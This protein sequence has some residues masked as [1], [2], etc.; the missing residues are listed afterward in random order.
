MARMVK[1]II[2]VAIAVVVV[3]SLS[4]GIFKSMSSHRYV[5]GGCIVRLRVLDGAKDEWALGHHKSTNDVPT[6]DDIRPYLPKRWSSE[7]WGYMTNG[8]P[9]CPDGGYYILGRVGG[10]CQVF[11]WRPGSFVSAVMKQPFQGKRVGS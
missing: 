3:G 8:I 9:Y 1:I 11:D 10:A 5:P 4:Y 2:S 7:P 6:W